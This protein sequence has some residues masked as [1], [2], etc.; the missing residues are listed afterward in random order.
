[1]R[2]APSLLLVAGLLFGCE[3]ELIETPIVLSLP[4]LEGC[5]YCPAVGA[6]GT[7]EPAPADLAI[8]TYVLDVFR[9]A[10]GALPA[11]QAAADELSVCSGCAN[12]DLCE[13]VQRSCVCG[14]VATDGDAI[15]DG[16]AGARIDDLEPGLYCVRVVMLNGTAAEDGPRACPEQCPALDEPIPDP[17]LCVLSDP[18][19]TGDPVIVLQTRYCRFHRTWPDGTAAPDPEAACMAYTS[20]PTPDGPYPPRLCRP[21]CT[22]RIEDQAAADHSPL[23][24]QRC[25][26]F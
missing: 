26:S 18:A 17:Q 4:M 19:Q 11:L 10:D 6:D 9:I 21:L 20:A 3:P 24:L 2:R 5:S 1:M 8:T 23:D 16:F 14:P 22:T 13:R 15:E 7:V 25:A 12:S